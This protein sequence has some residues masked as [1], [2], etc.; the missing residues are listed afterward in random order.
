MEARLFFIHE[1]SLRAKHHISTDHIYEPG[2]IVSG[3]IIQRTTEKQ[4]YI[5][6]DVGNAF[7]F[8]W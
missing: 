8:S 7:L 5:S 3:Q 4:P 2:E 6:W 1:Q